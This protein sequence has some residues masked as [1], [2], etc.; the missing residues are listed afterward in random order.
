MNH[1]HI[2]QN[3]FKSQLQQRQQ[4]GLW[5]G[6]ANS[7]STEIAAGIGYDWLL[8]D[9]EHA[10]N[11]L[12]TIL[13]QLQVIAAYPSQAVVR[14]ITADIHLIKQL[15]DIGVKN[16][17]LPQI[18][19]A[20]QAALMVKA[21]RYPPQGIRGVGTALARAAQWGNIS[22][23]YEQANDQICLLMQIESAQGLAQLDEILNVEGVDGYFIGPADLA[24][25]LGYGSQIDNEELQKLIASTIIKIK[26]AG[27]AAGILTLLPN[28]TQRYLQLGTDF[29]AVGVDTRLLLRAMTDL[30]H[31]FKK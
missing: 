21:V 6:L 17:L 9:A 19:T 15:L 30:L 25:S 12:Q 16:I 28:I 14:P 24:A 18:E 10:P 23:Y 26:K 22:N 1:P 31:Q 20:Q 11:D 8:I 29:V 7:Y 5:L 2:L 4:L 3:K 27:K 13:A